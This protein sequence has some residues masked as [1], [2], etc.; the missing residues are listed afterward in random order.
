MKKL[1]PKKS[2]EIEEILESKKKNSLKKGSDFNLIQ[3]IDVL[4]SFCKLIFSKIDELAKLASLEGGKPIKDSIIE[5]QRGAEGVKTKN[6][7]N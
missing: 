3:R 4:E 7:N 5:I 1:N 2:H 6:R